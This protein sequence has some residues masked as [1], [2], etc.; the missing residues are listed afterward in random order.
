[1][2]TPRNNIRVATVVN[3]PAE[4]E[5]FKMITSYGGICIALENGVTAAMPLNVNSIHVPLPGENVL[6]IE[7]PAYHVQG[8]SDL[9][10]IISY[11]YISPISVLSNINHNVRPMPQLNHTVTKENNTSRNKRSVDLDA[12][13][14]TS[15]FISNDPEI[16][17][18]Q[19]PT[20]RYTNAETKAR[21]VQL[22]PE[23]LVSFRSKYV[24]PLQLFQGDQLYQ[25]R[26]GNA[27]R[28]SSTHQ[29][30]QNSKHEYREYP[31]WVGE[32]EN[33]PFIAITCGLN[34][35][36]SDMA[37]ENPDLD[38]ST[39]ML[40]SRQRIQK[41]T[42]SQ[43]KRVKG[44]TAMT[45]YANPQIVITSDRLVFNSKQD[46][47]L[48]SGKKTVGIATPGWAMDMNKM[49]DILEGMLSEL[50]ALTSAQA[51]F[52]TGV[53]PSGPSTNAGA[54]QELL[55][56]LRNMKQ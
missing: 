31:Y 10:S 49:F 21:N 32:Q 4:M 24:K 42:L 50:A 7:G 37:V 48:L 12:G 39:I 28:L 46:E 2:I 8:G 52:A 53:G 54:V 29:I 6:L 36:L 11:Y 41:M 33:D 51:T 27:I 35:G 15:Q 5:F 30:N 3:P 25:S 22:D 1:M 47:I 13:I 9:T 34:G 44:F 55:G 40:S 26:F 45:S 43:P 14:N 18:T 17:N 16:L 56:S 23:N 19:T 20:D 38:D